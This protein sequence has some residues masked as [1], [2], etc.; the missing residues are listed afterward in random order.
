MKSHKEPLKNVLFVNTELIKII[1]CAHL[2]RFIYSI[3]N[4]IVTGRRERT[5]T[6]GELMTYK[7]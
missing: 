2:N 5:K 3:L 1:L 7:A 4:V 6:K